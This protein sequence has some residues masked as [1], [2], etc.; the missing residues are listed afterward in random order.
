[1]NKKDINRIAELTKKYALVKSLGIV[2]VLSEDLGGMTYVG[3]WVR[4][5]SIEDIPEDM[6]WYEMSKLAAEKNS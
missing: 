5:D 1:M 2:A 4:T 3:R 6:S